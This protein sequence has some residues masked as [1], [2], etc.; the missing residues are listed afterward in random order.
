[1]TRV[2]DLTVIVANGHTIDS[3]RNLLL[4]TSY[5]GF[6]VVTDS[7]NPLLLGYISRNELSYALKYSSSRAGRDLPGST[8][9][10]FAHQPF[11]DPSETLDLRPWMDQTPIT[12]NSGTTFLIVRRMFQR[13]G[14]RYVLFANKGVLQGLL[15]KKDVWSIIDG[16][17]SRRVEDLVTD[18]FRQRNTAE[19]VGLLESDDG[20]SLA[21]S[22]DRR[23]SL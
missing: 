6:P 20:T 14:L 2:E 7:S 10:F 15:T 16:A 4:A 8:Q 13:L 18:S 1:M 17:E 12:L 21:S 23:P 5:R 19:E 11:A 9:V 22:L 3:L